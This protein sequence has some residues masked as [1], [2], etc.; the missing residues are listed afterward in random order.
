[1]SPQKAWLLLESKNNW[2]SAAVI[3]INPFDPSDSIAAVTIQDQY[4]MH[5]LPN[6]LFFL[7]SQIT[8]FLRLSAQKC[9]TLF[10]VFFS[11]DTTFCSSFF[12]LARA[13]RLTS[14]PYYQL[15][16]LLDLRDF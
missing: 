13:P 14:S 12:K 16:F 15:V 5:V 4:Q 1:M 11:S 3:D 7:P 8:N 9:I 6:L 10:S 2:E